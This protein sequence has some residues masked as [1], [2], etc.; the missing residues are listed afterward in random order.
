MIMG[1][2]TVW[3]F[4]DAEE[5]F[6]LPEVEV[7]GYLTYGKSAHGNSSRA[8]YVVEFSELDGKD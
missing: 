2:Q 8:S 7:N 4:G 3:V 6:A 1:M 5:V